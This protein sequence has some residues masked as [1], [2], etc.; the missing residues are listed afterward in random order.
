MAQEQDKKYVEAMAKEH[1][2]DKPIDTPAS[3]AQPEMPVTGDMVSLKRDQPAY[4]AV[5]QEQE[6]IKASL[7]VIHEW[8]GLNDQIKSV[9]RQLAG[10]GYAALAVN[11]YNGKDAV[12]DPQQ[13][14][15]IMNEALQNKQAMVEC[16]R[17]A[18]AYLKEQNAETKLGVIGWCFGGGWAL[19]TSLL[20]P[21]DA[22]VIYY[23]HLQCEQEQLQNQ[24]K[25]PILGIFGEKDG[26]ITV[27]HVQTFKEAL[28]KANHP[29]EIH[30]YPNADHAFANP[31]G[32]MYNETAA[33]DAWDKTLA[34]FR[35]NL[36]D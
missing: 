24:L 25:G 18:V 27:E 1:A 5:P 7:V 2:D 6:R 21:M 20:E 3:Q 22:T 13:A 23:G 30:I 33:K 19:Q 9:T 29:H 16:L 4:W 11:L 10:Q 26:S 15:A 8:W 12:D 17:D 32:T 28:Q 36:L 35:K 14:M 34:F 31:S